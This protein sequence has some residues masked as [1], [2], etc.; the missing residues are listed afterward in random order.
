MVWAKMVDTWLQVLAGGSVD[1]TILP[2]QSSFD[3]MQ[4]QGRLKV[5]TSF[6]TFHSSAISRFPKLTDASIL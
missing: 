3:S 2:Y 5:L 1:F 4:Q 6:R